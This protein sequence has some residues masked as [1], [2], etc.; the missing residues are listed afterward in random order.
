MLLQLQTDLHCLKS[1][2]RTIKTAALNM[3]RKKNRL[4][5]LSYGLHHSPTVANLGKV[6]FR[7]KLTFEI[8]VSKVIIN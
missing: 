4:W 6:F 8:Q 7:S 3:F 1:F 5:R 2:H